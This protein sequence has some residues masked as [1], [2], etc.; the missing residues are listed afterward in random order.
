[1]SLLVKDVAAAK[2]K[3][4]SLQSDI[5]MTA[6]PKR[7]KVWLRGIPHQTLPSTFGFGV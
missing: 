3:V 1:M 6:E 4:F 2:T 5:D 7:L